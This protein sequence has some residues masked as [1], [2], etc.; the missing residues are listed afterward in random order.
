MKVDEDLQ[1]EDEDIEVVEEMVVDIEVVEEG[2]EDIMGIETV[3]VADTEVETKEGA[4][5]TLAE[6]FKEVINDEEDLTL[7]EVVL[8]EAEIAVEE[9]RVETLV[10]LETNTLA[11]IKQSSSWF[12]TI[13][14]W[15][16]NCFFI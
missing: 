15:C 10:F 5:L 11:C 1:E 7:E 4:D 2:E 14:V 13:P 12:K 9:S 3:K 16:R 8:H 6:I